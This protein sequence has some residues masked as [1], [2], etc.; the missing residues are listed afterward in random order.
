MVK[1]RRNI[2][3]RAPQHDVQVGGGEQRTRGLQPR[4]DGAGTARARAERFA[5]SG[6]LD[7]VGGEFGVLLPPQRAARQDDA[8]VARALGRRRHAAR[9]APGRQRAPVRTRHL[10]DRH[11]RQMKQPPRRFERMERPGMDLGQYR[12]AKRMGNDDG[13][14]RRHGQVRGR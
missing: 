4:H 11:E 14:F 2:G 10:A 12:A 13:G 9:L 1:Q 8:V 3:D 5:G 6:P 7:R